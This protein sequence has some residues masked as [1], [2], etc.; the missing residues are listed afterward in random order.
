MEEYCLDGFI[1]SN[2][3]LSRLHSIGGLSLEMAFEKVWQ[4]YGKTL[5]LFTVGRTVDKLKKSGAKV[6]HL[7]AEIGGY[8]ITRATSGYK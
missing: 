4:T 1:I 7:M 3:D 2:P 5:S 8:G 6:G